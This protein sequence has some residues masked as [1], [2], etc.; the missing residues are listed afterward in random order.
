MKMRKA[1]KKAMMRREVGVTFMLAA[2]ACGSYP[3]KPQAAASGAE[4]SMLSIVNIT[5]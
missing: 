2:D 1:G 4:I 3:K 5:V